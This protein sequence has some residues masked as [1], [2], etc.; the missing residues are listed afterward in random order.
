LSTLQPPHF[1]ALL[2]RYRR[3]SGLTQEALAARAGVSVR[4]IQDL[5]R[6]A[7]RAPRP[8]TL[9]LLA[10]ALGLPAAERAAWLAASYAPDAAEPPTAPPAGDAAPSPVPAPP[11]RALPSVPAS[12]AP[13]VAPAPLVGRAPELVMLGRFLADA[14]GAP[15]PVLLLAGEPGVGKTRLLQAA[16]QDAVARGWRVLTGG[17]YRQGGQEP[18]APL[19]DALARHL[20]ALPP[21]RL[22]ADLQGCAWLA[23]LLPEL[24]AEIGEGDGAGLPPAG[25]LAPGQER[26]LMFAAVARLLANAA[27]PAG[28]LLVLDDLQWAGP[29]ALDLLAALVRALLPPSPTVRGRGPG[30]EALLRILGAYRD[31]EVRLGDPLGLLVADLAQAG[32]ASHHALGPLTPDD[33][34]ALLADLLAGAPGAGDDGDA[35][36]S[37]LRRAGGVPFFLVSYAQALRAGGA[38]AAESAPWDAAQGVRQR[39]ALLPEAARE[40]LGAAAVIGRR[41]PRALLAAALARPKEE[42]LGGL[43]AAGRARLLMEEGDE[44]HAFAHDVI[45]EV[46]EGDLGA[47]R[48]AA[49]HR[50]VA[51]ALEG[52]P[53]GA[54]AEV[55]AYHHARGGTPDKALPYLEQAGDHARDQRAHGT[56]EAHY[57]AA[58]TRLEARGRARDALR[59]REKLGET[60]YEASR[61]DET[62]AMLVPAAAAHAAAEDWDD[63]ARVSV[64]LGRAHSLRGIPHDGT[65]LITALLERLAHTAA[66]PASL[67]MLHRVLGWIFFT[68]GAYDASLRANDRAAALA[69]AADDRRG[70]VLADAQRVNLLQMIEVAGLARDP[71]Q[72]GQREV[73]RR[74]RRLGLDQPGPDEGDV[75]GAELA[76]GQ[77]RVV[78]D[79]DESG[80][81]PQALDGRRPARVA[82][83]PVE[84][85]MQGIVERRLHGHGLVERG[86]P[87]HSGGGGGRVGAVG[88]DAI[89]YIRHTWPLLPRRADG[90]GEAAGRV[91]VTVVPTPS[92]LS[93]ATIPPCRSTMAFAPD[94]PMPLPAIPRAV[95]ARKNRS[96]TRGNS[97]AGMPT[98]WSRTATV[99]TPP[100]ARTATRTGALAGLYLTALPITFCNTRPNRSRSPVTT[101]GVPGASTVTGAG[102]RLCAP[103]PAATS[104]ATAR[105]STPRSTSS[106][107]R[108]SASP[109]S[110]RAMSLSSSTVASRRRVEAIREASCTASQAGSRARPC[111]TRL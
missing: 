22:R 75:M 91:R 85:G 103:D 65:A 104:S 53:V 82:G 96:V 83:Q 94:R 102:P 16:A 13:S 29:D 76:P 49:L 89:P 45:R 30:G 68:A 70:H 97:A 62:I 108:S 34:A 40:I 106:T 67:A 71:A 5:E 46:V 100:S 98:P 84:V 73:N 14:A 17:C 20:H 43:E 15:G 93:T 4:G 11:A 10:D 42:L 80:H 60:L 21:A 31:T 9:A 107:S 7:S 51:E 79:R 33:A 50:R 48:R 47:A 56:A 28:T 12:Q 69:E 32:L 35:A 59:V 41:A 92:T 110:S 6:G 44:A 36:A 105:A 55:L 54:P 74:R 24:S 8:D 57:R 2:R 26:R 58:L 90:P 81:G 38:G 3:A 61:Y 19:L 18:Y 101:T 64:C 27:G 1:G 95:E 77:R 88:D 86:P 39:V 78:G 25:A 109:S 63:L 23:R 72:H 99:A 87:P 66:S 37:V 111:A 52:A